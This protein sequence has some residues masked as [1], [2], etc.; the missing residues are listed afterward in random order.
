MSRWAGTCTLV[1][2]EVERDAFGVPRPKPRKRPVACNVYGI[3]A[4]SYYAAAQAGV[5]PRAIL[6]VRACAYSGEGLVEFG[7]TTYAVD[8]AVMTGADNMRLT[9]VERVGDR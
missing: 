8:N 9:L 6:E 7:G 3:S 4:A 2:E 5:R 1:G